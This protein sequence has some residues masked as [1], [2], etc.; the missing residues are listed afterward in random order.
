MPSKPRQWDIDELRERYTIH[1]DVVCAKHTWGIV[2]IRTGMSTQGY[3]TCGCLSRRVG[4]HRLVWMLHYGYNPGMLDHINGIRT[5]NRIC[6]LRE[7]TA[8][9]NAQNQ[10]KHREGKVLG[11]TAYYTANGKRYVIRT[12]LKGKAFVMGLYDSEEKAVKA[13]DMAFKHI[14]HY[15]ADAKAYRAYLLHNQL[16]APFDELLSTTPCLYEKDSNGT[17]ISRICLSD[18]DICLGPYSTKCAA[19]TAHQKAARIVRLY[20]T[21]DTFLQAWELPYYYER[22]PENPV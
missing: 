18:G 11:I 20:F 21:R 7:A 3:Q 13:R 16:I 5:D 10:R 22:I 14:K 9:E 2:P 15:T 4:V 8:K 19:I 6:N 17:F 1:N 12:Q